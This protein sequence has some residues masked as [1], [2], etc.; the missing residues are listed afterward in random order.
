[1]YDDVERKIRKADDGLIWFMS[2]IWM[3]PATRYR[4]T[5]LSWHKCSQLSHTDHP[6]LLL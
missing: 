5:H 6:L 4:R 1:M 2:Y 3:F